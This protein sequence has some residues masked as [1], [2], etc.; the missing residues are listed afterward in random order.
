V[1]VLVEVAS[2]ELSF[3][4][5]PE[6]LDAPPPLDRVWFRFDRWVRTDALR[7]SLVAFALVEELIGNQFSLEGVEMPAHLAAAL[8]HRF[9]GHELFI[10]GITNEHRLLGREW[11]YARLRAPGDAQALAADE[12][13]VQRTE[14]GFEFFDA[15]GEL[16]GRWAS[17][18]ALYLSLSAREPQAVLHGVL[19]LLAL[20]AF[21]VRATPRPA[22]H[23]LALDCLVEVGGETA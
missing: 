17:N 8:Q 3:Q 11:R 9:A 6:A 18:V 2:R 5:Q 23:S 16:L 12:I 1:K 10:Q 14:L 19:Y 15:Q 7:L 21:L 20:D 13:R 4:L 22:A